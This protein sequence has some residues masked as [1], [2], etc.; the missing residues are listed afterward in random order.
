[1][2]RVSVSPPAG[3]RRRRVG[4]VQLTG[5][6]LQ[7]GPRLFAQARSNLPLSPRE[8]PFPSPPGPLKCPATQGWWWPP[9]W[10]SLDG[11]RR[12]EL[13][14]EVEVSQVPRGE[15]ERAQER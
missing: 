13:E 8:P 2:V 10:G 6:G 7:L 15:N 4:A 1:M 5:Q 14:V 3:S 9:W 12:S 11:G